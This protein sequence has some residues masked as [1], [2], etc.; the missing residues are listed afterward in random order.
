MIVRISASLLDITRPRIVKNLHTYAFKMDKAYLRH[1]MDND[2][3]QLT[4]QYVNPDLKVNRQFNFCRQLAEPVRSF[5]ERVN[6]N[7]EK[8]V[9]K[10]NKKKKTNPDDSELPT[11]NASLVL[12]N[13]EVNGD[14]RCKDVFNPDNHVI[15]KVLNHEY[16]VIVNSPWIENLT[17]PNS[18]LANFP[19][20]P[21]KFEAVYTD[22]KLSEFIWFKSKDKKEWFQTGKG[23]VYI[24]SNEDIN[25]YLKLNCIPK[26]EHNEGPLVEIVSEVK[27]QASPGEC[28]FDLRHEYTKQ[29]ATGKE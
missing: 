3:F 18:I 17:L 7:V 13:A 8:I 28:P 9:L 12:N 16:S 11:I 29:R 19:V 10:R 2:T 6:A 4:F 21:S 25:Q 15:L 20:Y 27:A 14:I 26:N 22:K 5:L 24:P 23:F 1:A